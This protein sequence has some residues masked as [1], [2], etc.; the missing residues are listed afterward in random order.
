MI[1][2]YTRIAAAHVLLLSSF[3]TQAHRFPFLPSS[4][5]AD[6]RLDPADLVETATHELLHGQPDWSANMQLIDAVN[7]QRPAGVA[8]IAALK[9]RLNY[10]KHSVG[11]L[12]VVLLEALVK[13]CPSFVPLVAT[14]DFLED[15]VHTLPRQVRDPHNKSMFSGLRDQARDILAVERYDKTLLCIES[16]GKAWHVDSD[17]VRRDRRLGIFAETYRALQRAGVHFPAPE[18]DE[19]APVVTPAANSKVAQQKAADQRKALED[20]ERRERERQRAQPPPRMDFTDPE[21]SSASETCTLLMD[22]LHE[23][24]P[25]ED[26]RRNELVEQIVNA[27]RPVTA[28]ITK[29]LSAEAH[30]ANPNEKLLAELI[31]ANET[32]VEAAAFYTGLLNGTVKRRVP[33]AAASHSRSSSSAGSSS[34]APAPSVGDYT[35]TTTRR[36]SSSEKPV[37]TPEKKKP[38]PMLQPP[39]DVASP[40]RHRKSP[41]ATAAAVPA[42]TGNA[43]PLPAIPV[44]V[45]PRPLP[46]IPAGVAPAKAAMLDL[47]LLFSPPV[48]SASSSAAPGGAP[49]PAQPDFFSDLAQASPSRQEQQQPDF[50]AP[51][52]SQ[53]QSQSQQAQPHQFDEMETSGATPGGPSPVPIYVQQQALLRRA[54][55]EKRQRQLH[56]VYPQEGSPN[57]A[58]SSHPRSGASNLSSFAIA[59]PPSAGGASAAFFSVPPPAARGGGASAASVAP[60]RM[61]PPVQQIEKTPFDSPEPVDA[62]AALALRS[63]E[64]PNSA[65][66]A[67]APAAAKTSNPFEEDGWQ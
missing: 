20:L 8:V 46:A 65:A 15:F 33:P 59:P 58:A 63:P 2:I 67:H 14:P 23:S 19:L 40:G 3:T 32:C 47:D 37:A 50:F 30:A 57:A 9:K 21:C 31:Q 55:E 62:F 17:A 41:A 10:K 12:A 18:R 13:N 16:W 22:M 6:V 44:G 48:A 53:P 1:C 5:M 43:R 61:P 24:D 60:Q 64:K 51:S 11:V 52:H 4:V 39:P 27:L 34:A 49:A 66:A 36:K 7:Q 54:A 38:V 29:R 45:A 42:P 56:A 28:N 26:L 35:S 25:R